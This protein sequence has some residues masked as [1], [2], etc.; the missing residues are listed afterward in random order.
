MD[1]RFSAILTK[2][3]AKLEKATEELRGHGSDPPFHRTAPWVCTQPCSSCYLFICVHKR[4]L[5]IVGRK[6]LAVL[7]GSLARIQLS[8]SMRIVNRVELKGGETNNR[9]RRRKTKETDIRKRRIFQRFRSKTGR[10]GR[11]CCHNVCVVSALPPL[12]VEK[13]MGVCF[14]GDWLRVCPNLALVKV[15]EQVGRT[16]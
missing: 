15:E 3:E 5:Y 16:P 12:G 4:A 7:R 10:H 6:C 2:Q 11:E 13:E 1:P 9:T 8:V 14:D